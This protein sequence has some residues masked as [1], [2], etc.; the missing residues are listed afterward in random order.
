MVGGGEGPGSSNTEVQTNRRRR[1]PS[2][3]AQAEQGDRPE[4]HAEHRNKVQH[5][6]AGR[7]VEFPVPCQSPDDG[8]HRRRLAQ[9]V[10]QSEAEGSAADQVG[11]RADG[12]DEAPKEPPPVQHGGEVDVLLHRRHCSHT[13]DDIATPLLRGKNGDSDKHGRADEADERDV[14]TEALVAR[15]TLGAERSPTAHQQPAKDAHYDVLPERSRGSRGAVHGAGLFR[16]VVLHGAR[17]RLVLLHLGVGAGVRQHAE[18]GEEHARED[19]LRMAATVNQIRQHRAEY[20]A[21]TDAQ[22]KGDG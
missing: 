2:A 3:T 7:T 10:G 20:Q 1:N 6:G 11:Q 12:P 8:D 21:C 17:L 19:E 15:H 14:R 4:K 5:R 9:G 22:R 16:T 13:W 18:E